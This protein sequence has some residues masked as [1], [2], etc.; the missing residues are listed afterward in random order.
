MTSPTELSRSRS[1][2]QFNP[3]NPPLTRAAA[4]KL[5]PEAAVEVI[6]PLATIWD[7]VVHRIVCEMM[8]HASTDGEPLHI[9]LREEMVLELA[10]IQLWLGHA[11]VE[12][13]MKGR[14][15]SIIDIR[16]EREECLGPR[17]AE[18]ISTTAR[19]AHEHIWSKRMAERWKPK[20][21]KAV[22]REAA[23]RQ[24]KLPIKPVEKNHFIPRWFI[25]DN[26]AVNGEV[27]RW[28]RGNEGL[29]SAPRG[30]G[31][32]GFRRNL[33]SDRLE[34]YFGLLEGDARKPI[35]MLLD[36]KPLNGP[37]RDSL[38]GFLVIQ[39]LRNPTFIEVLRRGLGPKLTK[40]GYTSDPKMLQKAYETLYRNN[41]LY[42]QLA[43][44]VMWSQWAIV[45]APSPLFVLPD[46]F[47][48]RGNFD[49]GLRLIAPLTPRICFVTL[50][51]TETEKRIVPLRL[52]A[53]EP[54][55]RRISNAL[56]CSAASEF[57]SHPDFRPEE[58]IR[59]VTVASVLDEVRIAIEDRAAD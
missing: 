36:T 53:D 11:V 16:Q 9:N 34:A 59:E 31:K 35:Q 28:R 57:L 51:S 37:Q 45:Q 22:G 58:Q 48:A 6:D 56:V 25:R 47:G 55:A 2:A 10:Q 26:W 49:G 27:L 39:I 4:L 14:D 5:F 33:Y 44:P 38:V 1:E 46:T 7:E 21:Q 19:M 43:H 18:V 8:N 12:K 20:S 13:R 3:A 40:L 41:D 29:S 50:L 17:G 52:A 15:P 32:W 23:P 42:H 54:L 30:F 24:T